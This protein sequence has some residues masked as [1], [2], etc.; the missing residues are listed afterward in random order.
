MVC[1]VGVVF[2]DCGIGWGGGEVEIG[3]FGW[4]SVLMGEELEVD[5][6]CVVLCI[7]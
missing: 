6:E 4:R 7:V 5:V 3:G 2:S 1:E